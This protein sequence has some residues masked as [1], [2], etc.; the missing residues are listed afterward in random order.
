MSY[1]NTYSI[2][3]MISNS[4]NNFGPNQHPEKLIPKT[5]FNALS[6]NDVPNYGNDG[7]VRDW[8][9]VKDHVRALEAILE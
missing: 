2:W 3:S 5:I 1:F 4:S 8:I 9:Y 7:E 6:C